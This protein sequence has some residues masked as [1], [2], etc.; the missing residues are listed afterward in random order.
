MNRLANLEAEIK[1]YSS[2]GSEVKE[3][4]EA[5][6]TKLGKGSTTVLEEDKK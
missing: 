5:T 2:A 4:F 6:I 1:R 3:H